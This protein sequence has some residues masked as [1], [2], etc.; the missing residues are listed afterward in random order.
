MMLEKYIYIYEYVRTQQSNIIQPN[1]LWVIFRDIHRVQ[2]LRAGSD[3]L[4]GL[5]WK[6][7]NSVLK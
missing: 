6:L 1:F 2:K 4:G 7:K 3:M 5:K